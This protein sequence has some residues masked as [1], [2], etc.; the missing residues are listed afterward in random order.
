MHNACGL[1]KKSI[2]N[3]LSKL[4]KLLI[5][6][7]CTD[8]DMRI[9]Y[10]RIFYSKICCYEYGRK[11]VAVCFFYTTIQ[12]ENVNLRISAINEIK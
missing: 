3:E 9:M 8:S 10:L 12:E 4:L 5:N 11:Y 1:Y 2:N 7:N 6:H